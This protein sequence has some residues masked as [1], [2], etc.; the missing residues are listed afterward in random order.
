MSIEDTQQS[1]RVEIH[2]KDGSAFTVNRHVFADILNVYQV[3]MH[4][5]QA[6]ARECLHK[7]R[8]DDVS[9]RLLEIQRCLD[10]YDDAE[11]RLV[12]VQSLEKHLKE[13]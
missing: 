2:F 11:R 12:E 6:D 4:K 1:Q 13:R 10:D 8:L 9:N 7:V 5:R 3:A